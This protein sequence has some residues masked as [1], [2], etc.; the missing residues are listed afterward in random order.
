MSLLSP[1][2]HAKLAALADRLYGNHDLPIDADV[3]DQLAKIFGS[4]LGFP[5]DCGVRGV[6]LRTAFRDEPIRTFIRLLVA[7]DSAATS[8]VPTPTPPGVLPP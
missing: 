2:Q 5:C 8:G 4:T 6:A 1:V 7:L 3:V